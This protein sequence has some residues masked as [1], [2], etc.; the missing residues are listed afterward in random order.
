MSIITIPNIKSSYNINSIAIDDNEKIYFSFYE[1]QGTVCVYH[2]NSFNNIILPN[3]FDTFNISHIEGNKMLLL[4]NESNVYGIIENGIFSE[5][6]S[7]LIPSDCTFYHIK[8]TIDKNDIIYIHFIVNKCSRYYCT[9]LYF[10]DNQFKFYYN[11]ESHD[12]LKGIVVDDNTFYYF[13]TN[14]IEIYKDKK[15]IKK[16]TI[17][18]NI[19]HVF[20]GKDN[21]LYFGLYY[22]DSIGKYNDKDG[23]TK[24][25]IC[26][27][28]Y[29]CS[30]IE[31]GNKDEIYI[32]LHKN[33]II[34]DYEV[35]RNSKYIRKLKP[36]CINNPDYDSDSESNYYYTKV[37]YEF[38]VYETS[39]RKIR[40]LDNIS[41][42]KLKKNGE[43]VIGNLS[44]SFIY[45]PDYIL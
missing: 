11:Y 38:G 14:C 5:Y 40:D 37:C 39:Y 34:T 30:S 25:K 42:M 23:Y 28:M 22:S 10:E 8:H 43:I 27:D 16:I 18:D 6:S 13:T 2:N 45:K 24:I 36:E 4:Q 35:I 41:E 1:S 12:C 17:D 20:C 44:S 26:D 3:T 31:I 15:F 29:D 9:T 21:T 33:T 19:G 7:D 32:I